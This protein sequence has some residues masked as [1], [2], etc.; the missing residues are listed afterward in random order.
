MWKKMFLKSADYA[1]IHRDDG[2]S[3]KSV[4]FSSWFRSATDG[5]GGRDNTAY[6]C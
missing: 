4:L 6:L 2:S 1:K 5:F 3:L